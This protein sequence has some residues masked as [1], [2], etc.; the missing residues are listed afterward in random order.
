MQVQPVL[1]LVAAARRLDDRQPVPAGLVSRLGED[2][3]DI[4]GMQLVA[5]RDHASIHLRAH[6]AVPD[7]GVN[8][9]GEIDR[10][11]FPRQHNDF[12]LRSK[13]IN[14]FRIKIDLQCRKKFVGIGNV[15][16]PL[17][18]LTKPCQPLLV[19]RR[20]GA[21]FVLPVRRNAF[22]AHL[23]HF[24]R[25]NLDLESLARFRDHRGV[26]RLVQ[27]RPRHGNEIFNAPRHRTPQIVNDAQ[28][29]VA[30]LY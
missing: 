13:G 16:L 30:I 22:F 6:A 12:P 25:A 23:V 28:H 17:H 7:F 2:L 11:R 1:D 9:V 10:R 21:V 3:D 8:G 24:F 4:A 26:Q 27:I 19:L 14:L 18:H 29:G 5:Q 20:H 15:P